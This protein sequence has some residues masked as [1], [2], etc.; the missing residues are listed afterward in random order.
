V[1]RDLFVNVGAERVPDCIEFGL[2]EFVDA[3]AVPR[4]GMASVLRVPT[5]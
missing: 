5:V 4:E 3:V 2:L 1:V